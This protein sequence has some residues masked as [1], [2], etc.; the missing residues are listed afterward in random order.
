MSQGVRRERANP[1]SL[2]EDRGEAVGAEAE[3]G[4]LPNHLH[5]C[6]KEVRGF[7]GEA[8]KNSEVPNARTP[9][10]EAKDGRLE[11]TSQVNERR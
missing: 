5:S 7:P 11:V 2:E 6:G 9:D 4:S 10:R 1:F 3:A 8:L